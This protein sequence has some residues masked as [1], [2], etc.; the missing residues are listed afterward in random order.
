MILYDENKNIIGGQMP[1]GI[2][3]ELDFSDRELYTKTIDGNAYY[4][5]D[6]K[7]HLTAS[8]YCWLKGI[9]SA[10]DAKYTLSTVTRNN[11]IFTVIMI[12]FAAIGG[13]LIISRAF[14]PVKKTSMTA[15]KISESND[16]SKRIE[17][18]TDGDEISS[19]ANTFDDMLGK[20]E[21]NFERE[22]QFTS[23][24]SHELRTPVAV[25]LSECEFMTECA[26][27]NEEFLE[28]AQSI[29]RQA[30]KMSKLIS[31]LLT[32]SRM[33]KKTISLNF[34]EVNISELLSFVL[35]EQEEI[36][37]GEITLVRNIGECITADADRFL[38]ARLFINIVSNA[39]QYASPGG[40]VIVTLKQSGNNIIFS[41]K[42]NGIGIAK[43]DLPK[44]WERFY[45][46]DPARSGNNGSIG[47]GL[48]MV[49][50]IAGC[51]NGKME[52]ES[53]P[54]KGSNFIFTFPI[55]HEN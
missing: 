23:D 17:I 18:G 33:D 5:Y 43:E 39:Y 19:L 10:D 36:R 35:D 34:E 32:I 24:A 15:K 16:L 20:L 47:L 40:T 30:E 26:S 50:W 14:V 21:E 25:I 54:G 9:A 6:K 7:I 37:G 2:T 41:V 44:I 29:K 3:D 53:E 48:S 45:Q 28:S 13:Y 52:V 38:L 22:K 51:H 42:D 4:I 8:S 49:K 46:A 12:V 31:E 27:T 55:K 1:F 11:I